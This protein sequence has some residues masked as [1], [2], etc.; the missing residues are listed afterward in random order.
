MVRKHTRKAK[1]SRRTRRHTRKQ[2]G[3]L[4]RLYDT[5]RGAYT[6]GA[7]QELVQMYG[8]R[9]SKKIQQLKKKKTHKKK[10]KHNNISNILKNIDKLINKKHDERQHNLLKQLF[11]PSGK[12]LM[13]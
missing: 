4:G 9:K 2:G 8:G 12:K 10:I 6:T 3:F 1:H 7:S 11:N 5:F 13:L